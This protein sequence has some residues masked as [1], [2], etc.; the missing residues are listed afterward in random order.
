MN[1]QEHTAS[2]LAQ[3]RAKAPEGV[4][5]KP[6][7]AHFESTSF[8][9]LDE[10]RESVS[11]S[12]YRD[13]EGRIRIEYRF[14]TGERTTLILDPDNNNLMILD[15]V[16]REAYREQA[17]VSQVGWAFANC[18]PAYTAEYKVIKGVRCQRVLL[19]DAFTRSA[20]GETWLSDALGVVMKDEGEANGVIRDWHVTEFELKEPPHDLFKVPKEYRIITANDR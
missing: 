13:Q 3:P 20:V 11:G 7:E 14:S 17:G 12:I 19:K 9:T 6:F 18:I 8:S 15:D 2:L 5:G 10:S 16:A 1:G 4:K